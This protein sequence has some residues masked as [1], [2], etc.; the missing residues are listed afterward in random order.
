MMD[1]FET[2]ISTSSIAQIGSTFG[3]PE[4]S[5][6]QAS[7][8]SV[9][10]FGGIFGSLLFGYICDVFGRKTTFLLT[11]IMYS[12]FTAITACSPTFWFFLLFRA[13]TSIGVAAEYSA[14]TSSVAEFVPTAYRGKMLTLVLGLWS[15]GGII[16]AA[17]NAV[18]LPRFPAYIGWRI[19]FALGGIA[20]IFVLWARKKIPE[21]PRFLIG[22]G[23]IDEA[24]AI[25]NEI[26]ILA[27]QPDNSIGV[28]PA[29]YPNY[30]KVNFF[31]QLGEL[32]YF[33]PL[34]TLFAC[35]LDL[36]QAFGGYG[37]ASFFSVSLLPIS[38]VDPSEFPT[39]YLIGYVCA[40]PATFLT[41]Y[42][43]DKIGR[44][45][46][47]PLS[48]FIAAVSSVPLYP[49][50]I[51]KNSSWLYAAFGLYNFGYTMAWNTGY[52]M[53]AELFPTKYRSTGIGFAVAIGRLGGVAAPFVLTAVFQSGPSNENYIGAICLVASFFLMTCFMAIPY[54]IYGTEAR[55]KSLEDAV[56]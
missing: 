21:S 20:A 33:H 14:V 53:Y 45:S 56:I 54:A 8:T 7:I 17:V 40:L 16:A 51:S 31:R 13:L 22:K 25:V 35:F 32:C 1:S 44:K 39:F 19:T 28:E 23:Q 41:A 27:G 52:P 4:G 12:V 9:W 10:T 34:K 5:L 26:E 18:I 38:G 30:G 50:A 47:L 6:E 43:I 2:S 55:G 49:A 29:D 24:E 37:V 36:S 3:L 46:L 15:V 42:L 11:L 48:Y